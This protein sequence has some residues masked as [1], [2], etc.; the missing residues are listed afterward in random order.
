MSNF[1]LLRYM[2]GDTSSESTINKISID[3][4]FCKDRTIFDR[5]NY[6]KICNLRVQKKN[7]ILRKSPLIVQINSLAKHINNKKLSF[8]I[9]TI[10]NLQNIFME[11]DLYLI[12]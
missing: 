9:F 7:L 1:F 10:G 3:V 11:Q 4:W 8:D 2:I 6:L 12:S 5:Y